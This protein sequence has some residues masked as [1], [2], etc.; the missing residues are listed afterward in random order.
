[1]NH[2]VCHP[3]LGSGSI[4]NNLKKEMQSNN[5]EFY[6][7]KEMLE[8][9]ELIRN[10]D[11]A[12]TQKLSDLIFKH[13]NL[14]LT[15]EGSSRLFPAKNFIDQ[16]L[17]QNKDL[18]VYTQGSR[19]ASEYD[20]LDFIVFGASNSGKTKEIISAF[21][22]LKNKGHKNLL[23]LTATPNSPLENYC[24]ETYVLNCGKEN[25]VAATKSV[26]EQGLFYQSILQG[27]EWQNKNKCADLVE[28][29][30]TQNI[31]PQIID[32]IANAET[33]YFAGRN[34]GVTEELALKTNEIVRK[35]SVYLDGTF[36]LHGIEEIMTEKDIVIII[37]PF[38]E[39]ME[40]Y[41]KRLQD[42]VGLN[43]I[44]INSK[45]TIFPT[46]QIPELENFNSYIQLAAGWNVLVEVGLKLN[47]NLDKPKRARK[48]GNSF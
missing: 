39:E 34:N 15:G 37:E 29:T 42:G 40:T 4:I 17:K 41:K 3:E 5:T 10:F 14:F 46:I 12:K 13:K 44:A 38:E 16:K 2:T 18:V 19:Q 27:T 35:K 24:N 33:I 22:K 48:V 36:V 43:V 32:T 1:M 7:I 20:L 45:D 21:D 23:G 47:I 9:P 25:A 26:V 8:V 31:D 30:L 28:Q 11:A 6:L